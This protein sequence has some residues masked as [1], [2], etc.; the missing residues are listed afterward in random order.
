MTEP[1]DHPSELPESEPGPPKHPESTW[2]LIAAHVEAFVEAWDQ[3]EFPPLI[4]DF[5][6]VQSVPCR[7]DIM[8]ELVKV[9]LEYR[10]QTDGPHWLIEDYVAELPDLCHPDGLPLE[11]LLEEFHVRR[12]AG[13]TVS[14]SEYGERFPEHADAI[15][16]LPGMGDS[17]EDSVTGDQLSEQLRPGDRVGDFYLMSNL[18]TGA[19]GSVYLARQESMQRL[20]ALKVSSDR[21]TEA[22]TLAQ[23]DHPNIVRVYDQSRIEDQNLRLLY[24]QFAPGG[25]LH[26]VVK[27]LSSGD[28]SSGELLLRAIQES[29]QKTGLLSS[30]NVSLKNGLEEKSWPEV[31]CAIGAELANALH[32]AHSH[33]ILHRDVKPANVLL[34]IDGTARL[35]DFNIS[36]CATQDD[37]NPT[38]YFGGSLAYMSPE[39]LSACHPQRP[40]QPGDLDARSDVFSLGVLLWELLSGHRPFADEMLSGNWTETLDGMIELRQSPPSKCGAGKSGPVAKQLNQILQRCLC[41]SRDDRFATAAELASALT[42]CQ[43]PRVARLLNRSER[44][45]PK[46]AFQWPATAILIAAMLPNILAAIFNYFYNDR[47][48]IRQ[49]SDLGDAFFQVQLTIN[50]IA[51]PA[52]FG[53]CLWYALPLVKALSTAGRTC[54]GEACR[55]ARSR[56]LKLGHF[57]ALLGISEWVI[58]GLA[59]PVSLHLLRDGGLAAEWHAHFFGSLVVCGMIAAAYPFFLL[60]TLSIQAFFP[61]LLKGDTIG[62][63]DARALSELSDQ[64]D[65][66]LYLAGGVPAAGILL[67]LFAGELSRGHNEVVLKILSA[68]GAIGF[69]FALKLCRNA[70]ADIEALLQSVRM[71]RDLDTHSRR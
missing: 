31:V 71:V 59:Y 17:T 65:S 40:T 6:P 37:V 32:Y 12:A 69:A 35:A 30:Q 67:L 10:H 21:G 57:I 5:V 4:V 53:F 46:V 43:Q 47:A 42:L 8:I 15:G 27:M 50:A 38:A 24:M 26:A 14:P 51:F 54:P 52:G 39:Q 66:A 41:P 44:G 7:R 23:L 36:F 55:I 33:G 70:Q 16:N 2:D 61:R 20:V 28:R 49:F 9:D 29:V 68:T 11:L 19:F 3:A 48:I 22:Q 25:T 1:L 56:S 45:W 60:S 62:P 58:A 13:I 64:M 63:T 18:G 34:D